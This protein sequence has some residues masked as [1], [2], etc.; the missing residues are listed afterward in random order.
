MPFSRPVVVMGASGSGKTTL[1]PPQP[2]Q[3]ALTVE[4]ATPVPELV[5]SLV[6]S[7]ERM[8]DG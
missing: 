3:H 1:E 2:D 7:L 6:A 8:T 4:I 5:P